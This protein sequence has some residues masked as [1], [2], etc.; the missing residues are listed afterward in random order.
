MT[1]REALKE[2]EDDPVVQFTALL[3]ELKNNRTDLIEERTALEDGIKSSAWAEK[4]RTLMMQMD[5]DEKR[6]NN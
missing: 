6:R 4:C 1:I 2:P 5:T 3:E